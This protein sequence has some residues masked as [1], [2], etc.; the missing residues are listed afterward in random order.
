[1]SDVTVRVGQDNAIKVLSSQ[2]GGVVFSGKSTNVIGGIA[3]VSQ[4]SVTGISTIGY[5]TAT[6]LFV[7]GV[8]TFAGTINAGIITGATYYGDGSNLTGLNMGVGNTGSINTSG[9]ITASKLSTGALN[10]GLNFGTNSIDGPSTFYLNPAS[11][12][13]VQIGGDL[14]VTGTTYTESQEI[15]SL[16][17][18]KLGIATQI[19]S[20][21]SLNGAGIGI[22]S[23]GAT[24]GF[25]EKTFLYNS[26]ANT[27]QSNIGFGL[28]ELGSLKSGTD[29]LLSR[30]TLGTTV[31]NSALTGVGTLTQLSVTG[32]LTATGGIDGGSY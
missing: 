31:L 11:S 16:G 15:V 18:A 2:V 24:D 1:M 17:V 22:G 7:T 14:R 10:T 29:I 12:G 30:T 21:A 27:L 32:V 5:A 23:T 6:E 8:S 28:T 3:S 9:I 25:F 13:T 4:I 20:N 19:S 26:T